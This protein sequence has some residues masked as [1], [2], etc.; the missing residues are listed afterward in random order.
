MNNWGQIPIH[1]TPNPWACIVLGCVAAVLL[2]VR[3]AQA[4]E[5]TGLL[6]VRLLA[7]DTQQG[8]LRSGLDKARFDTGLG[9]LRKFLIEA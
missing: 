6:D 7:T 8:W 3:P 4:V 1:M 2:G 9:R 5:T